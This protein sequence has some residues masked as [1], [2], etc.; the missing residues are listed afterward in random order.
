MIPCRA[1][2]CLR[3]EAAVSWWLHSR[4]QCSPVAGYS[5]LTCYKPVEAFNH[6]LIVASARYSSWL[7]F[8]IFLPFSLGLIFLYTQ[9]LCAWKFPQEF[10]FMNVPETPTNTPQPQTAADSPQPF[11]FWLIFRT[12]SVKTIFFLSVQCLSAHPWNMTGKVNKKVR[13]KQGISS[14]GG[15]GWSE[16]R[17]I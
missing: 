9:I 11:G 8:R 14:V 2:S 16:G 17:R 5:S 3:A 10:M 4:V 13:G 7:P 6:C 1:A 15:G 12:N